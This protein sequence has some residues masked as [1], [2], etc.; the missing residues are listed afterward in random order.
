MS[1]K[2]D[3]NFSAKYKN[4]GDGMFFYH[5]KTRHP[6]KQISH[7]EKT[8]TNRRYTHSPNRIK[9]YEEDTSLS[10]EEEPVYATRSSF[11]DPIYTRGRP[12]RMKKKKR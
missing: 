11:V 9:D 6:A 4:G 5:K 12:Y 1:K 2:K 8:W 3:K 10:T 7:A